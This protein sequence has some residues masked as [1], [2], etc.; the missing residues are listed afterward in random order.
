MKLED[1][2]R[3][4]RAAGRSLLVP[5]VTGRLTPGWT[6][7]LTAYRDAGAD[8]IEIGLP[9]SDPMLDGTTLQAASDRALARGAD[10]DGILADVA[11]TR[12]DVPLVAMTYLNLVL[13][14]GPDEFCASLRRAG[15]AGLIV[16]DAPVDEAAALETAAERAGIALVL[17]AAP[18]TPPARLHEIVRRTTG[19]VYAVTLMGAT[20]ERRDLTATA[21]R[22]ASDI[23]RLTDLPT[24]LGF[25]I[26]TPEHA[27][28]AA[29]WAD[30]VVVASSL[31][32]K[33]LDGATPADLAATVTEIRRAL[34]TR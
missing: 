7:Y 31:M 9:F 17:L 1:F 33:V 34:P 24:L 15:F 16:P 18:S 4:R 22:L 14:D 27:A 28:Q 8:A 5:Y 19:F 21:A 32:R 20:G 6:D 3:A 23:R 25:G 11:G 12:L 10:V 2:L 26:S 13:R 29:Q 30:G